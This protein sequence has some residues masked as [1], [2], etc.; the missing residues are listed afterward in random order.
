MVGCTY[1][2]ASYTMG[3]VKMYEW[4]NK[5]RPG[6]KRSCPHGFSLGLVV[7]FGRTISSAIFISIRSSR[8]SMVKVADLHPA[9]LGSTPTGTL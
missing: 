8:G 7:F 9:S 4:R 2:A 1:Y 5:T 3:A 6:E